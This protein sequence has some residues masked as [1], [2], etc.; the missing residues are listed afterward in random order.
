MMKVGVIGIG[1]MGTNHVRVYS[2][3]PGVELVG[4]ADPDREKCEEAAKTYNTKAYIDYKDLLG[5]GLDGVSIATPTTLHK[6]IAIEAMKQGACVLVEKPIADTVENAEAM[7]R[8]AKEKEV[9]L[10]VGHI[11]RFNPAIIAL[12][13]E[14]EKGKFGKI[15][16]ISATRV[17]PSAPRVRDV[18]IILDLGVHDIDIMSHLYSERVREVF[19]TAGS[20]DHKLEDYAS[21]LLKF[22]NGNAG[23][24]NTNWLTPHKMRKLSVTGTRGI[25]YVDNIKPSVEVYNG[26]P[27]IDLKIE[28]R[29]PLR[30]ELEHFV[31]CVERDL[32][33]SV[34]GEDGKEALKVAL[35]AVESY[36]S[37]RV[38]EVEP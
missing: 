8:A 33:P 34:S 3:M 6:D 7:I 23:V 18:G 17:G 1:S 11:E 35:S 29:E 27:E 37:G 22:N 21:I 28:K 26:S 25:A 24:I 16:S 32:E 12:K 19:A 13:K 4:I 9:K 10:M 14:I 20:V 31:D 30:T 5:Q 2:Q 15:V 38:V 36:K